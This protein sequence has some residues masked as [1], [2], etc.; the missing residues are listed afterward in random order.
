MFFERDDKTKQDKLR[1]IFFDFDAA[2]KL[3]QSSALPR[4]F[5]AEVFHKTYLLRMMSIYDPQHDALNNT[6]ISLLNAALSIDG[7]NIRAFKSRA[8]ALSHLQKRREEIADWDRVLA[9]DSKDFAAYSDRAAAKMELGEVYDAIWDYGEAI[10]NTKRELQH[11]VSYQGR[12]E[13]YMK[14]R[15][16][17]LA[18]RDLTTA[19]SLEIGGATILMN[20]DQ[21]RALYPEY[22]KK[23]KSR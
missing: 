20:I 9:L 22:R 15:Q 5:K 6:M 4:V 14:T 16:W 23:L 2:A 7:N 19:I 21:F 13:A 18:I 11:S 17:D 10:R 3:N 12:A 1:R 8:V